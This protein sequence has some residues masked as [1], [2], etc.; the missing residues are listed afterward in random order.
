LVDWIT[1]LIAP[2]RF[3]DQ[4]LTTLRTHKGRLMCAIKVW[5]VSFLLTLIL[6]LPLYWLIGIGLLQPIEFHLSTFVILFLSFFCS[7]LLFHAGFRW[8]GI[9]SKFT[10]TFLMQAITMSCYSPI[11]TFTYYAFYL[12]LMNVINDAHEHNVATE[13]A[14]GYM[15]GHQSAVDGP[16]TYL[17]ILSVPLSLLPIAIFAQAVSKRYGVPKVKVLSSLSF[18]TA[19]LV[20]LSSAAFNAVYYLSLYNF[21]HGHTSN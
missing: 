1:C 10:K 17:S 18:S 2:L 19:I 16:L 11:N 8:S 12:K 15:L 9:K 5:G 13:G 7:G 3:S 21:S 20:P 4:Q 14:L 6:L